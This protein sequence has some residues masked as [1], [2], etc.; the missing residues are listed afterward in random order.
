M[1]YF[2][3]REDGAIKIGHTVRL[4]ARVTQLQAR[5]A[6]RLAVLSITD[7]GFRRDRELHAKFDHLRLKPTHICEWFRPEPE[8]M[9]F[10]EAVGRPW[11]PTDDAPRRQLKIVLALSGTKAWGEWLEGYAKSKGM[12][13][14]VLLDHLARE[15]AKK[16]GYPPPPERY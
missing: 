16:D 10:I 2:I 1:I 7:G 12:P 11:K 6:D 8:L 15:S 5:S 4:S 3:R 9:E 14:V 13:V